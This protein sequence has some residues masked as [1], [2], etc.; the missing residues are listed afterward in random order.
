MLKQFADGAFDGLT[1]LEVIIFDNPNI[2][3]L[4]YAM[5]RNCTSLKYAYISDNFLN[6]N[7]KYNFC[8]WQED[9]S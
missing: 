5:V 1:G 9:N 4:G 3:E 6:P 7:D 2:T 8:F